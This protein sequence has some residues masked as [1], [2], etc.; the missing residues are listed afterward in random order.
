METLEQTVGRINGLIGGLNAEIV[1]QEEISEEVPVCCNSGHCDGYIDGVTQEVVM[2]ER[3][4]FPDVKKREESR[5]ELGQLYESCS[6][7]SGRYMAA[8]ALNVVPKRLNSDM[9]LWLMGLEEKL[10]ATKIV[11]KNIIVESHEDSETVGYRLPSCDS[12]A[13][14]GS[15]TRTVQVYTWGNREFVVADLDRRLE[16]I[17]DLSYLFKLSHSPI[18]KNF[19]RRIYSGKFDKSLENAPEDVDD[20]G[21]PIDGGTNLEIRAKA[22]KTLGYSSLRIWSKLNPILATISGIA[23]TATASGI[24]Y[25]AYQYLGK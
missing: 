25:M 15:E 17:G 4:A 11:E 20:Y 10:M 6:W 13:G 18:F 3:I 5:Q 14:P 9:N 8:D 7:Y 24:G 21:R 16:S 23:A 12:H 19:L 1:Q 22:G 2:Q